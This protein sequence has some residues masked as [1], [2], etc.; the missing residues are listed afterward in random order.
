VAVQCRLFQ[1]DSPKLHEEAPILKVKEGPERD[2]VNFPRRE[3]PMYSPKVHLGFL[4]D[5]WFKFFYPK[6]GVTGPYMFGIGLTTFLVSKEIY[7]MEHEYYTGISI[8]IMIVYAAKKFGPSVGSFIDKQVD[9]EVDQYKKF[10]DDSVNH[11]HDAIKAEEKEQW[12]AEGQ[13]VLFDAKKEN[14]QLQL[15]AAYR[16]RLMN[17]YTEVKKRLDYQLEIISAQKRLQQKHMVNWIVSNV[18]K[19][20]T[21]Q[22]EKEALQKCI[23]DLKGLAAKA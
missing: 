10:Y 6:T 14:V 20:I 17:A 2:L 15:E 9:A 11:F 13:T 16:E 18:T 4:P 22:Q 1:T 5:D 23:A 8:L 12:R 7:V 3:R 19:S 21:P